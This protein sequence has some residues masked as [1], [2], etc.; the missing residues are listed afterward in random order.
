MGKR[1]KPRKRKKSKGRKEHVAK[2]GLTHSKIIDHSRKVLKRAGMN[3]KCGITI[4]ELSTLNAEIPDILGFYSGGASLIE[5]KASRSDFLSDKKKPFRINPETGMGNYRFYAC[6]TG[7]IKEEE[8][9]EKWG[10]IY[11]SEKGR[12][13]VKVKPKWQKSNTRAE[14]IFMYS[15][16]RRIILYHNG[17]EIEEFIEK[18]SDYTE[19]KNNIQAIL[20]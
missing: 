17:K 1:G 11:V 6:P 4:S 3:W 20:G 8:I 14:H 16:I 15:I 10:L 13:T 5:A 9:P 2:N 18:H 19:R 12:C 7:L